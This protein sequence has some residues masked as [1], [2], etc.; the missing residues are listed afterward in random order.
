MDALIRLPLVDTRE[1]F[2]DGFWRF[3]AL[4]AEGRYDAALAGL[5]WRSGRAPDPDDFRQ[6]IEGFWGGD[7]PWTVVIPNARLVGVISDDAEV[8]LPAEFHAQTCS[9]DHPEHAGNVGWLRA[10]IPVTN[11]P[12]KAKDDDVVLMG[13]A[14]S[15]FVLR[16]PE[17][18]ALQFEIFHE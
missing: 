15:F 1:T 18:Y 6:R 13:V 5:V 8:L 4:L 3:V 14:A 12:H 17:G 9:G 10:L 11:Q 7:A 16:Q 2:L